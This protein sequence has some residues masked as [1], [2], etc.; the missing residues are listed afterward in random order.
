MVTRD[1]GAL[2]EDLESERGGGGN[3]FESANPGFA[4]ATK[5]HGLRQGSGRN[6]SSRQGIYGAVTHAPRTQR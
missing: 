3:L 4:L 1:T 6:R 5:G 2:N